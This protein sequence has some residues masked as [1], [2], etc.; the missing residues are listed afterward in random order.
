MTTFHSWQQVGDWYRSLAAPRAIPTPAI[1]A[2]ADTLTAGITDPEQQARAIYNFVSTHIRYIGV[3]FGIGRFEP[4]AAATVLANQYGDCKDKDT[5]LESLLRAKGFTTAPALIGVGIDMIPDLPSP[6]LFN[7]VI[8]TVTLPSGQIW[9][10]TTPEVAPFRMLLSTVRDKQALVIPAIAPAH[11]EQTQAHPPFPLSDRFIATGKL[12][13]AGDLTAHVV[14]TDRSDSGLF[15]RAAALNLAPAQWDQGTQYLVRLMGFGGTVT[16]ASFTN[17]EDLDKPIQLSYDYEHPS[18]GDWANFRILPL[19]PVAVLPVSPGKQPSDP[20]DLG[21]QRIDLAITTLTLPAGFGASLPDA[22]HVKTAFATFDKTYSLENGVLT[23]TRKI[24]IL[25]S[26]IPAASWKEYQKFA[27]DTSFNE[28]SYIPLT[29]TSGASGPG[30]HPPVAGETDPDAAKLVAEADALEQKGDWKDALNH[31]DRARAIQP[32]QPYLWS[33]YGFVAAQQGHR[34]EAIQDFRHELAL[35]P[36]E[37]HF[38]IYYAGFLHRIKKDKEAEAVLNASFEHDP[39]QPVVVLMLA[40]LQSLHS[41]PDAIATLCKGIAASP[42]NSGLYTPLAEFLIRN[43]QD[44][45]AAPILKKQLAAATTA[46]ALNDNSYL[47]AE[48]GDDL[49]LAEQDSRKSLSMLTDQTASSTIGE[50]NAQSFANSALLAA[51]WDT[52]GYILMEENH[53][54]HAQ[55]YLE[56][57]WN[58]E[59]DVAVGAHYGDLLEQLHKPAA[60]LRVDKIAAALPLAHHAPEYPQLVAAIKR[61]EK[62]GYHSSV[63]DG[64]IDLQNARTFH[65]QLHTAQASFAEATFRLQFSSSGLVDVLLVGGDKSMVALAPWIKQLKLPRYVPVPSTARLLRDAVVTCSA[66]E[67]E[68]DFV[69]MP[70]GSIRAEGTVR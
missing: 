2:E 42:K 51:S 61:L 46:N 32:K 64:Q 22:V 25:Q 48:T 6:G 31:L 38:V 27:T 14:I 28:F 36:D 68:C 18:F 35:H 57:A 53:P 34:S 30:P 10:D 70:M 50:A 8:T 54:G 21:A 39:A 17:V 60:A 3:D 45:E 56:A 23:V 66:G 12:T 5:L 52:L 33:A 9:L 26:K 37:T 40:G 16:H 7:H 65:L 55:S 58:D 11:L 47:L 69:V 4:H 41:L 19:F 13:A 29:S 20:I 67:K 59:P 62:A 63:G 44:D 15:L 43:H 49:P 24:V 1:K